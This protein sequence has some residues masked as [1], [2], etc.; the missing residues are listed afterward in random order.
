MNYAISTLFCLLL[1]LALTAQVETIKAGNGQLL[2]VEKVNG[3]FDHP[4]AIAFLPDGE[5]LVTERNTGK[6]HRMS[7]EMGAEKTT[8]SGTPDVHAMGQ[9]GLMDI[10]LDPNFA[11]NG[12]VY[13]AYAKPGGRALQHRRPRAR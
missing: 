8:I 2:R 12:Y 10:K 1:S 11:T 3:G 6:L 5:V 9:G 7:T 13:L 4:W